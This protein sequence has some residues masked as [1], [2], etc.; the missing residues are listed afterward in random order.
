MAKFRYLGM[1][2]TNKNFTDEEIKSRLNSGYTCR[3]QLRIFCLSIC[4]LKE[5]KIKT[6]KTAILPVVLYG[7]ET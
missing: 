1:T 3:M 6:Y 4:Y 7:Y 5:V 2:A